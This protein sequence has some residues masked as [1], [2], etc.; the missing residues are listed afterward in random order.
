VHLNAVVSNKVYSHRNEVKMTTSLVTGGAGFIGSHLVRALLARGDHVRV[1][2]N[3][4]TGKRSNLDGLDIDLREGDL[5]DRHQV[6]DSVQGVDRIFHQAAFV[7]VPQ[8]MEEPQ[9]CFDTNIIGTQNLLEAA[10][11][12]GVSRIVMASSSAVYGDSPNIPLQED[13]PLCSLSPYAASKQIGEVFA[14]VYSRAFGMQ[15]T[16]LRYFNV[17]GERQSPISAYAAVIPI[18]IKHLLDGKPPVI[19]GDGGQKRDFVYAQDVAR[20]NIMASETPQ[21]GGQVF[22]VCSGNEISVLDL[23]HIIETILLNPTPDMK[24]KMFPYSHL[25]EPHFEA[26]RSGDIYRSMGDPSRAEKV[27]GFSPDIDLKNGLIHTIEGMIGI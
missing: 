16:A 7:S 3:F 9:A 25:P 8:S 13:E 24:R 10:R 18:F 15:V 26:A 21:A 23:L 17:Y 27:L 4:S 14:G 1:F 2:D 6:R 19:Y 5:R 12:A 20:A 22:N 11:Q